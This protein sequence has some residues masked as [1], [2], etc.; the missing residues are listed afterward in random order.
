VPTHPLWRPFELTDL[1]EVAEVRVGTPPPRTI[2]VVP[3]DPAW[4][5][6]FEVVAGQVR[7]ALGDRVLAL[8]HIGSTSVPGL[9]AKPVIDVDLTVADSADEAAYVP[10]LEA[11]GFV[12]RFRDPAWEEHRVL[13]L[14]TPVT[15]L[16]VISP[17]DREAQ[18]HLMFREWLRAHPADCEAYAALKADLG[19]LGF[20][21][22][23]DY[24]NHKAALVYDLYEKA[25]AADPDHEHDPQPRE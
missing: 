23:M 13:T 14:E 15:N 4:P 16:H 9:A 6:A 3:Y 20:S 11:V 1:D 8:T 22:S 18:R 24:N 19:S 25:F 2:T 5:A 7:A 12:L 10:D 21:D 17:G